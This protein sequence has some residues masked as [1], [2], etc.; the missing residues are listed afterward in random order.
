[1]LPGIFR[2]GDVVPVPYF[3]AVRFRTATAS[4][5]LKRLSFRFNYGY[6]TLDQT[7]CDGASSS[8]LHA[9][10]ARDICAICKEIID[11]PAATHRAPAADCSRT[12]RRG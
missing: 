9:I 8:A 6:A 12:A 10:I 11:G 1:M 2:R 4:V 3:R 7:M 5:D